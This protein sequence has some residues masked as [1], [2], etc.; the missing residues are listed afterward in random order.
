LPPLAVEKSQFCAVLVVSSS[1]P[2]R[3]VVVFVKVPL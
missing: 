2:N 3:F 1:T